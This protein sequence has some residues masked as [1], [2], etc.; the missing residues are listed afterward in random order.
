MVQR[1]GRLSAHRGKRFVQNDHRQLAGAWLYVTTTLAALLPVAGILYALNVFPEFG[2]LIFKEQFLAFFL[3]ICLVLTFL[4]V[5]ARKGKSMDRV[6]W[7]D[8]LLILASLASGLYVSIR[9]DDIVSLLGF[10]PLDIRICSM[11]V[12]ALVFEATRRQTGWVMVCIGAGAVA[13]AYFGWLMPGILETRPLPFARLIVSV[14]MAEDASILSIPLF[15]AATIILAFFIFG[16]L[17]FKIG[18]G[19]AISDLAMAV[20]GR[21]R[22]GPAKVAVVASALFG[23]LSGSASA[24][25]ATT[26][27]V[28][29]PMMRNVG[30]E[31]YK[32][33]GIEAVASTGGLILPPVMAATAFIM[34][35]FL[36]TTYATIAIAAALPA[37]LYYFC[38]FLQVDFEAAKGNI[39]GLPRHQLPGWRSVAK[40]VW[41][42]TIPAFVLVYALFGLF[43]RPEVAGLF[44]TAATLA[45]SIVFKDMRLNIKRYLEILAETGVAV[46]YIAVITAVAGMVMGAIAISGLGNN[47]SRTLVEVSG[48]N[49]VLLL[50]LS[51]VAST[52]LGMG[53]PVTATYIILVVLVGPALIEVGISP[54]AAHLF[55]F[56]FGTLSFLTPPVCVSVFVAAAI[57]KSQPM[58]T[59]IFSVRLAIIAYIIP[60]VFVFNPALLL[61]GGA[62][63]IVN[64]LTASILGAFILAASLSGFFLSRLLVAERLLGTVVGL[65]LLL[66][67]TEAWLPLLV[68]AIA[69]AGL[70]ISHRRRTMRLS[71]SAG[72]P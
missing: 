46:V 67:A 6:P 4:L 58:T 43:Q 25:V 37:L 1:R 71:T 60:F 44:A 28:T 36:G 20:M 42:L 12:V 38:V 13:Y 54:L 26:G 64:A 14:Y 9:F 40:R 50:L 66:F 72:A 18:G 11:T 8:R 55:V 5:P 30:Y 68:G 51:A 63:S 16:Q 53:V 70:F 45:I 52:I 69:T 47:M 61:D 35:E 57:A 27:M 56:Y 21:N 3:M 22:G 65:G 10:L 24:N 49:V 33:A 7:Y 59:A 29:I 62:A 41:P 39:K 15:V 19:Q 2:L 34:A 32:A 31:D 23:S 17:L 48:G